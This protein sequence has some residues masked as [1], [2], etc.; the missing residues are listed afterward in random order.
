MH[1][2][3]TIYLLIGCKGSG[4]TIIGTLFQKHFSIPFA[5][6]EDWVMKI[7]RGSQGLNDDYTRKVF[8]T[9]QS[10]IHD[11]LQQQSSIVFESTGLTPHFDTMLADLR[12][13]Y[14]VVMIQVLTDPELCLQRVK[15]RDPSMHLEFS[16]KE[17]QNINHRVLQKS[18]T[19]DYVIDNNQKSI[20]ELEV[21]IARILNDVGSPSNIRSN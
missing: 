8:E 1:P 20:R 12:S 18:L 13:R 2:N 7:E 21:E 14:K 4:K 17:I 9:I 5:R 11:L 19:C 3:K 16:D 6:V 10:G 15:K